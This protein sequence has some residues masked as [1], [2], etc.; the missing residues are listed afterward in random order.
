MRFLEYSILPLALLMA[1]LGAQAQ[2]A[3][4]FNPAGSGLPLYRQPGAAAV[5]ARATPRWVPVPT[6]PHNLLGDYQFLPPYATDD[7]QGQL[8]EVLRS[9]PGW[10]VSGLEG[11]FVAVPWTVGCGCA[12]EGWDEPTWVPPGAPES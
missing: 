10:E 5:I 4:S 12:E 11:R 9:E 1:P 2:S 3:E 8:F 7:T 6:D